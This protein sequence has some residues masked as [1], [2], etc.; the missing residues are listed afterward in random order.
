[1][2]PVTS[3]PC[4]PTSVG[5]RLLYGAIRFTD[6]SYAAIVNV[7]GTSA[8]AIRLDSGVLRSIPDSV[9]EFT[10]TSIVSS[11][12]PA[13]CWMIS[14]TGCVSIRVERTA[15]RFDSVAL[16]A[17]TAVIVS[18]FTGLYSMAR[19]RLSSVSAP[20]RI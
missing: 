18:F 10:V 9:F 13:I 17:F 2:Y 8:G 16:C 14:E 12:G 6:L 5:P 20:H 1:M 4:S 15:Y 11:A 19:Y 3:I 7:S